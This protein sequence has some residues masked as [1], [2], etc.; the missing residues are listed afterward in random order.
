MKINTVLILCAG[1]GK[2]LNPLTLTTPK[3]LLE[4]NDITILERCI[5]I[6]IKLGAKK[7]F[8]NTF[9]LGNKIS[10]FIKNKKFKIDIQ[11][12]EDGRQILDTGGGILNMIKNSKD[13]DFMI[14]NPDTLWHKDYINE[15]NQMDDFY[16]SNDLDNILLLANK[17]LSFDKNLKGNFNIKNN[18]LKKNYN[19]D[20][21]YIG[22]QILNR[23]LFEKYKIQNFSISKVWNELLKKDKLNGFES[24][25]KFYHLT[26]LETFKKLQDL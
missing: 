6:T 25:N 8:L 7:I 15:I 5:D 23:S 11:I 3:P 12:I 13:N 1:L 10:D 9:H 14:F 21:I 17:K 16:F 26:N 4:L 2:R 18:L 19:N 24:L 20:Y 22:C